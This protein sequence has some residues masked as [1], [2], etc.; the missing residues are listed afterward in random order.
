MKYK[1]E[2]DDYP[3]YLLFT[4]G[5]LENPVRYT[6]EIKQD[7]IQQWLKS[8]GVWIGMLGCLEEYDSLA[9]EF[10]STS[11]QEERQKIME[12]VKAMIQE[13]PDS[14]QK[15]AE[16]YH[17]I[18]SK[19]LAQG[20]SFVHSEIARIGKL[21]GESKMSS[22][23][24]MEF[25]KR[26]NILSSF[27]VPSVAKEDLVFQWKGIFTIVVALMWMLKLQEYVLKM[28]CRSKSNMLYGSRVGSFSCATL[29]ELLNISCHAAFPHL[30]FRPVEAWE[31]Q[32]T[33]DL[34][35]DHPG[36]QMTTCVLFQHKSDGLNGFL[37]KLQDSNFNQTRVTKTG[38]IIEVTPCDQPPMR[39]LVKG[40][41]EVQVD[42]IHSLL[43][44]LLVTSSKNL[45]EFSR[46]L[47]CLKYQFEKSGVIKYGAAYRVNL[48]HKYMSD[49]TIEC[50]SKKKQVSI[51]GDAS[52]YCPSLIAQRVIQSQPHCCG[53]RV[54]RRPDQ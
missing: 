3:V 7:A 53:S 47:H 33:L 31:H 32:A 38:V 14:E 17:K 16:Q 26:Q 2:K 1:V 50:V 39:F 28:V 37:L 11:A 22:A 10:S 13:M 51:S 45:T 46:T 15:S 25:Q 41:L 20:N 9:T 4:N 35:K 6:G 19:V 23:K 54:T 27:Q 30:H 18:M 24:K 8:K 44:I 43:S 5:D 34:S 49:K 48:I 42:N 36:V 29:K 12:K 52:I 21:L 40:L